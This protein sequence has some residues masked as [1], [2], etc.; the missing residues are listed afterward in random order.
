MSDPK[1]HRRRDFRL[2][3][4]AWDEAEQRWMAEIAARG[5]KGQSAWEALVEA[6]GTL[7]VRRLE[8][9]GLP[10]ERAE[11][12]AQ[13]LWLDIARGAVRHEGRGPVRSFLRQVLWHKATHYYR[14]RDLERTHDSL[15]DE[16]IE[17]R[18]DAA[19]LHLAPAW[20]SDPRWLD[21]R[22]CVRDRLAEFERQHPRLARLLVFRHVEEL[23]LE[24]IVELI[25]GE[26]VKAK[27][28]VFSARAKFG[29][30]VEPCVELWP[31]R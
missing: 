25:G 2:A 24:E 28:E 15:A 12:E 30:L 21:F 16:Q 7:F 3:D 18:A 22:R 14:E 31:T 11:E 4:P 9:W 1:P 29:P 20:Q 17:A 27:A 19:L 5:P 8:Y 10:P 26:A 23:S 13:E 6:Y